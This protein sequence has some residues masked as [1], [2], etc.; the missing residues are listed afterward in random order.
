MTL[1][2]DI[3]S[4]VRRAEQLWQ[5]QKTTTAGSQPLNESDN[6][7]F[8]RVLTEQRLAL[9]RRFSVMPNYG[10]W[11]VYAIHSG[12]DRLGI[13]IVRIP[14]KEDG[15]LGTEEDLIA[16]FTNKLTGGLT[17]RHLYFEIVQEETLDGSF[18]LE[19][20]NITRYVDDQAQTIRYN[21]TIK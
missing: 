5:Q 13:N 16:S 3:H 6:Q 9:E 14:L 1:E 7:L 15:S 11:Q 4:I 8:S 21:R 20:V 17:D 12:S 19:G 18:R 10:R 2:T